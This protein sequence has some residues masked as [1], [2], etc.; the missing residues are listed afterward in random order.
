MIR[1]ASSVC[2]RPGVSGAFQP[3]IL[4]TGGEGGGGQQRPRGIS[5]ATR[6]NSEQGT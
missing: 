4:T 1:Q 3:R 2:Q 6:L 5:N